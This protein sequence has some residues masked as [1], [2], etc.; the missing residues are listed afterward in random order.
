M[1]EVELKRIMRAKN[2]SVVGQIPAEDKRRNMI[3]ALHIII[4][5][6]SSSDKL[7]FR[8]AVRYFYE[9]A[10]QGG[11]EPDDIFRILIDHAIEA[12]GPRSRNPAAVFMSILKKEYGY[13]AKRF[14]SMAED[15]Q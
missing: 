5:P 12:S 13:N 3:S 7:T 4:P 11:R 8:N 6:K 10:I 14:K 2:L 15:N 1:N 9:A